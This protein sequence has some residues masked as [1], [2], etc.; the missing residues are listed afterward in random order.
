M[1]CFDAGNIEYF[2]D[3]VEQVF[4]ASHDVGYS[5]F[6]TGIQLS[7]LKQLSKTKDRV[8]RSTKLVAHPGEKLALGQVGMIRLHPGPLQIIFSSFSLRD[9][10]V[11]SQQ[12]P[13]LTNK[14]GVCR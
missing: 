5:F 9:I 3:Q 1:T 8:H 11:Y 6:L 10:H 14:D 12:A 13:V 7:H 4:S 2:I